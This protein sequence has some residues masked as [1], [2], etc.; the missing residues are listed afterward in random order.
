MNKEKIVVILLLITIILSIGSIIVSFS[1]NIDELELQ[2]SNENL[3]LSNTGNVG[4]TIKQ[5]EGV[6][7][8]V[9]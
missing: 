6:L 3:P 1:L 7:N 5:S 8:E 2:Q 4:L 9:N